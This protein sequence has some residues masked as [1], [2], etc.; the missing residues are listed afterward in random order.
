VKGWDIRPTS[1]R[2]R[3]SV[4]NIL[5]HRIP[6][7]MVLDLFAGTGALGLE[8]LSRGAGLAVFIDNAKESCDIIQKNITL[9]GITDNTTL[10]LHDISKTA[11]PEKVKSIDFDLVFMDPPYGRGLLEKTLTDPALHH[12]LDSE[13]LVIAEHSIQE[14]VPKNISGLDI[15]DQRKYGRTL[16]TFFKKTTGNYDLWKKIKK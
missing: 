8:A 5:S 1:D 11:V 15:T 14:I 6:G 3:E 10:I 16:V 7:T 9:C 13:A 2:I 12:C 4:F